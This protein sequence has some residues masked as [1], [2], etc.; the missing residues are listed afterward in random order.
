MANKWIEWY[1]NYNGCLVILSLVYVLLK[2]PWIYC[3]D[4]AYCL[5]QYMWS[6][7]FPANKEIFINQLKAY[8]A[9]VPQKFNENFLRDAAEAFI[10]LTYGDKWLVKLSDNCSGIITWLYIRV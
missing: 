10:S 4:H 1:L 9:I 6:S 8:K 3:K 7:T 2:G 5:C